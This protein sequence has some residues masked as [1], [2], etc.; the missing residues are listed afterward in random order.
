MRILLIHQAFCGPNDPGGTRHYE[1]AKELV[2]EGHEVTI[3]TSR[4]NYLSGGLKAEHLYPPGFHVH[5]ASTLIGLHRSYFMRILS[6]LSFALSSLFVA[7]GAGP[8]DVILGTSPPIFQAVTAAIVAIVLR[9][10]FVLEV[11]DL[12][13]E[14]AI[15]LGVL[16][17]S[18]LVWLARLMET[19]L[20][21]CAKSIVVNSPAFENYLQKRGVPKSKIEIVPNGA[22]ISMFHPESRGESFRRAHR[23]I[24]NFVVMYAGALGLANGVE[25][26]LEAAS[27]LRNERRIQLVLVGSGKHER[28][29]RCE[30]ELR[31]LPN[32]L[33]VPA[34]P[35]ER[36]P[37]ILAAADA[38]VATL[39]N[40]PALQVTFP[41]KVFDYMA[42]GRPTVLA[43]EGPIR[44]VI[45]KSGGGVCI[46]PGDSKA[47]AQAILAL[48]DS[49]S[50][51]AEM[52]AKAR[53][54]VE[55][56]FNRTQQAQRFLEVLKGAL[57]MHPITRS[58]AKTTVVGEHGT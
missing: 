46:A 39:A 16:R 45:E 53:K 12:W 57:P 23:L 44:E 35:K 48:R 30:A 8:Q 58:G 36:I 20:Y 56:N 42:A 40:A 49:S 33:F 5:F 2:A 27:L 54:H 21:T 37:E 1:I 19:M 9:R 32:V 3:V 10:P 43:V 24:D 18:L 4:Y 13:P 55:E 22:D 15:S 52:G 51:R 26:L 17:N 7:L 38:C 34:Q 47:L 29:L 11:R 6:F 14:F 31:K 50:L 41:N 25:V 28:Q